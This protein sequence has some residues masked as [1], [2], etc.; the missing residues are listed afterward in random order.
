MLALWMAALLSF[1]SAEAND[2]SKVE[3]PIRF[4]AFN[5]RAFGRSKVDKPE[6]MSIIAQVSDGK[7]KIVR[8][9]EVK[10]DILLL[11]VRLKC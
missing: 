6:V 8:G 4:G 10:I 9:K 1:V 7:P 5:I 11:Y 3:P 2:D